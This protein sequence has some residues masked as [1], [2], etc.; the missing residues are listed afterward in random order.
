MNTDILGRGFAFPLQKS[1]RGGIQEARH[2]QKVRQSILVILG[3]Q[4]GERLMRPTFGCNL[5]TLVFAPNNAATA[6]L[7]RYYVEEGLRTWEPRL[8]LDEVVVA[9]DHAQARLVIQVHYHLRTTYEPQ[10]LVYPFYLQAV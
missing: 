9:N 10:N 3:T 1:P 7:A 8:I 6:N 4:Y 2:A 5:R